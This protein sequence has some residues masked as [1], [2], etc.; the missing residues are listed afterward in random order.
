MSKTTLKT[1]LAMKKNSEKISCLTCYDASFAQR[2]N[3]A[4]IDL[5]LVGDSLGMVLQGHESTLPVMMEQMVYHT[6]CVSAGNDHAMIMVDMPFMSYY[7]TT[8]AMKNAAQLMQAGA[9]IVKLEGGRWLAPT[10]Q[11]LTQQGIPVCAHLGLTP[12]AINTLGK[13]Q[14]QGKEPKQAK[15][16]IDDACHLTI[17]GANMILLEC[18]PQSVGKAVSKAVDVPVIGIGA[19]PSTDAQVLVLH[20]MLGITP[21][22]KA[23]FVK[24]FLAGNDCIE[25]AIK[26]YVQAVKNGTF[27][28][29]EHC[30]N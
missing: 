11:Q 15:Q 2:L 1:L 23:R 26:A 24:N 8:L 17:S 22:R 9:H 6:A 30:F 27:P 16:I 21:G 3:T 25:N 5:L 13:Y 18:V 20:D 28:A 7:S 29:P 4:G 10:I 14:L 12:Q 19:G